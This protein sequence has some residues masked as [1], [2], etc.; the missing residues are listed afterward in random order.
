MTFCSPVGLSPTSKWSLRRAL[1]KETGNFLSL[2]IPKDPRPLL[3][4]CHPPP[5]DEASW[6]PQAGVHHLQGLRSSEP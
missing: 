4:L 3:I 2:L 6:L 1:R 5:Q